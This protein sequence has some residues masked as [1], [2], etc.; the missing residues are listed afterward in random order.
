MAWFA[1]KSPAVCRRRYTTW[2]RYGGKW[3]AASV[4]VKRPVSERS[5]QGV[6]A[7]TAIF[8]SIN[9]A[10]PSME[11]FMAFRRQCITLAGPDTAG[12]LAQ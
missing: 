4:R 12:R 9:A 10:G 7:S 8:V 1:K 5:Q 11:R 6:S 3:N 2:W